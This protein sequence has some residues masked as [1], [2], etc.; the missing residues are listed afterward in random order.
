MVL[1]DGLHNDADHLGR[2]ADRLDDDGLAAL[3]RRLKR[4]ADKL[5]AMV[6]E[7][8]RMQHAAAE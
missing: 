5:D 2:A 4:H 6:W 7:V 3:S 1:A 8:D